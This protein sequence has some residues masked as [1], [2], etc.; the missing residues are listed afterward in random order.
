[1]I[2]LAIPVWPLIFCAGNIVGLI[3]CVL[4]AA[5]LSRRQQNAAIKALGKIAVEFEAPE[6]GEGDGVSEG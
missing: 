5:W 3:V 4:L 2:N 1:M 6:E